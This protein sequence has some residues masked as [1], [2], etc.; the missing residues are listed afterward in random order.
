MPKSEWFSNAMESPV[1]REAVAAALLAGAA[2]AAA[3]FAGKHSAKVRKAAAALSDASAE[4]TGSL[5]EAA[6]DT[7]SEFVSTITGADKSSGERS[8]GRGRSSN[9]D[10]D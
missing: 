3:V 8:S 5:V 9:L 7:A 6:G 4:M 10:V 2:A 1:A